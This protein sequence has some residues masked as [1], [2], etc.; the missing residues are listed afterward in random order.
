M[1]YEERIATTSLFYCDTKHYDI[2]LV[3]SHVSCY[4]FL[5][6]WGQK[7]MQPFRSWISKI[8]NIYLKN[9]SLKWVDFFHADTNVGNLNVDLIIIGWAYSKMGG[10]F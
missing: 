7:L 5:G 8:C 3:S 10:T 1:C 2:S 9:E 6:G 4:L